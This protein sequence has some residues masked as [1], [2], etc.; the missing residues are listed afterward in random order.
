MT[1]S[2]AP[3]SPINTLVNP[4]VRQYCFRDSDALSQ[5]LNARRQT[6]VRQLSLNPLRCDLLLIESDSISFSFTKTSCSLHGAGAKGEGCLEF[7]FILQSGQQDC[8]AH[9]QAIPETTLFGFDP[10][11]ETNLIAPANSMICVVQIQ[12]DAFDR[13]AELMHRSDLNTRFLKTNFVT[14]P[15]MISEVQPYL[16]QLYATALHH[17]EELSPPQSRYR[18]EDFI[19]LLIDA[20]PHDLSRLEVCL[21]SPRRFELV[22]Q[23]EEY[24]R[25]HLETPITLMSLCQALYTSERPLTYGFREVYGS[26]P[27]AHLKTLRLYA[28]RTQLQQA[29]PTTTVIADIAKRFG[30]QSLGHFS[31][32]YKTMFGELP[33]ETLKQSF[34]N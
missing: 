32:D 22:K 2:T 16:K 30:F 1:T 31:R 21:Q 18:L 7:G 10:T 4:P 9:G 14:L 29:E 17:P 5:T 8:F 27:M 15:T 3:N 13:C 20:I 33:S 26:S 19:P 12:Q 23:A 24:M 34:R 6:T 25:S 11:R 28:V